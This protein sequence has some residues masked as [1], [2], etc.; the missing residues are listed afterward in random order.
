MPTS[1]IPPREVRDIREISRYKA[2][3]ISLRASI[4]NK[5]HALLSKNGINIEFSDIF[6]KKTIKYLK[7]LELR[8]CYK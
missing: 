2:S 3:L 5:V 1:Y 7:S 4:K 6:G 8:A